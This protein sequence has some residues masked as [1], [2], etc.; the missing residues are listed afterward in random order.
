MAPELLTP[1]FTKL[2]NLYFADVVTPLRGVP[3]YELSGDRYGLFN[4]EFR[5]PMID[6]FAMRFPIPLVI[7]R[8]QGSIF[9][10]VGAAWYGDNFKGGVSELNTSRLNDI[11]VGFGTG[12]R[13]NLGFL[14]LRYDIAW[15][16]DLNSVSDRASH[17]FSFGADF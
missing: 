12:M 7:S 15:S 11:K 9:T 3:Y 13:M 2:K 4:A 8:I 6:Y 14:L 10:D 1:K 5:F 17:Y 16:T